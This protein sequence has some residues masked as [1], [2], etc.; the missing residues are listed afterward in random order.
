[1][2][3]A[4]GT[5]CWDWTGSKDECGYGLIRCLC[6]RVCRVHRISWEMENGPLPDRYLVLHRCDRPTCLRPAHL[7]PGTHWDN[8]TD[9]DAKG[10]GGVYKGPHHRKL[11]PEIIAEATAR[12]ARDGA[13]YKQLAKDYGVATIT[14][15]RALTGKTYSFVRGPG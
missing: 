10:R 3:P 11:S 4:L 15:M 1:M 2:H 14:I 12:R 13:T 7:F 6:G 5:R 9:R 8:A